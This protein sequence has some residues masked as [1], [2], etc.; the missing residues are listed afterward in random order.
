MDCSSP[1]VLVAEP[2]VLVGSQQRLLFD[3]IGNLVDYRLAQPDNLPGVG[4][5]PAASVLVPEEWVLDLALAHILWQV[6]SQT[7]DWDDCDT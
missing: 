6:V 3:W 7:F 5:K 1:V 2:A 4:G